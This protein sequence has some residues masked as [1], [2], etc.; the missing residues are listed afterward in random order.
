M[1]YTHYIYYDI[2]VEYICNKTV[3]F[4]VIFGSPLCFAL[5]LIAILC[6]CVC[7]FVFSLWML[8]LA[9]W[10]QLQSDLVS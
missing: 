3:I 2:L 9:V 1:Y 4:A 6:V 5:C 7:G 10:W 8:S